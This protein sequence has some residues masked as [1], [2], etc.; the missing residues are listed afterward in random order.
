MIFEFAVL[1]RIFNSDYCTEEFLHKLMPPGS[2]TFYEYCGQPPT[3]ILDIGSGRGYWAA[4]AA[5]TWKWKNA[6]VTAFDIVDLGRPLRQ[7]LEPE[8]SAHVFW[9]KGNLY[10]SHPGYTE[11]D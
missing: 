11:H 9:V 10:V 8:I 2:P 1:M 5:T 3:D 6:H 7:A 4:E